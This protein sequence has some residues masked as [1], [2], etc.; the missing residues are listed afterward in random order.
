MILVIGAGGQVG[1]ALTALPGTVGLTRADVDL[2]TTTESAIAALIDA[3]HPDVVVNAAAYTAVDR[4]E[5]E[6][7]LAT[8]VNGEVVGMLARVCA[9]GGIRFVTYSTDYVFDGRGTRPY[10][11][12]DPVDPIN[13]YGR[14]KLVGERAV[15][16]AGG[17]GLIIRTSWVI[18]GTHPNFVATMLRLTGEGRQ[19]NVIDDQHGRPTVAADLATATLQAVQV[20]AT[21]VLHLANHGETSWYQLARSAVE[22]GGGDPDLIRPCTTA[23]YPTPAERPSY[24]TLDTALAERLGIEPL[25]DWRRSLPGVVR[26]LVGSAG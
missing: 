9:A 4:A 25:P 5:T 15:L 1:T 16:A 21:G 10:L 26:S 23:D 6:E 18:S 19:L 22:L 12:T 20:G 17:N 3:H 24:S 11:E 8:R 13:A 7:D 2:A 14:S